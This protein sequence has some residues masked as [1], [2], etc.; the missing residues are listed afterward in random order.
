MRIL[1]TGAAGFIGFHTCLRLLQRGDRVFGIDNIKDYYRPELKEARLQELSKFPEFK[2]AYCDITKP[3][4]VKKLFD[5]WTFRSVI[6]LA[7]QAGVRSSIR[8]PA[9]FIQDNIVGFGNMLDACREFGVLHTM[10]ASSSSVYGVCPFKS[11]PS[12][13]WHDTSHP[14]SLYAA[15]KKAN[16]VMAQSY[17]HLFGMKLTGLRFFTVYGPYGR[18]D[19]AVWL[20]TKHIMDEVPFDVYNY[21]NNKRD[22]TFIDD[23]VECIVR[24]LGR[25]SSEHKI[26]N[27]GSRKPMQVMT[28]VRNLEALLGKKAIINFEDAQP[29]DVVATW[30]DTEE[31]KMTC[32][33]VPDTPLGTG[34]RKFVEWYVAWRT[35]S[36][37]TL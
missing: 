23:A 18:P 19:M 11:R 35:L 25:V 10:Y 3:D 21:G 22:F 4:A 29:G 9:K 30:A 7:G 20:F 5:L 6:H 37:S 24:L 28:V 36:G 14:L 33:Y 26:L 17:A 15:T 31:L 12:E 1:V 8:E 27:V 13:E 32:G 2:F 16:E 34:L